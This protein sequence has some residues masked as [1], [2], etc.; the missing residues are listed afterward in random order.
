MKKVTYLLGAFLLSTLVSAP[1]AFAQT[2]Q[3]EAQIV[4]QASPSAD[5]KRIEAILNQALEDLDKGNYAA[6]IQ[7]CD[8][9]L[10]IDKGNFSAYAL[11][12]LANTGLK[13][14]KV[15]ITDFEQAIK[16]NPDSHY[17]YFGKGFAFYNLKL[18]QES[19]ADFDKTI[20]IDPEYAHA[21][22]WRGISKGFL[23]NK[24]GAISDLRVAAD[25]YQKQGKPQQAKDALDIIK[26]IS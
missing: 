25:L 1:K 14:Y 17:P 21:Y 13:E 16:I 2:T 24:Q 4:V 26:G 9:I 22:Y 19:V 23:G 7:K 6:V 10:K 15:A 5:E 3:P 20:K 11:R 18:Y 12:G 8:T